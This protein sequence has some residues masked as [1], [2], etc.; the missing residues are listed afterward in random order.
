MPRRQ[1][2]RNELDVWR[3]FVETTDELR[4]LLNARLHEDTGLSSGDY[5]LLLAL[6]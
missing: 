5:S 1:P 2:T 3:N 4:A 6:S